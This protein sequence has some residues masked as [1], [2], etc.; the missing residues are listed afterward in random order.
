MSQ[1]ESALDADAATMCSECGAKEGLQPCAVCAAA[2]CGGQF[3]GT[4]LARDHARTFTCAT[5]QRVM[6]NTY[7][8]GMTSARG[9]AVQ[10]CWFCVVKDTAQEC[11]TQLQACKARARAE[12][13][14]SGDTLCALLDQL[15]E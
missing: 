14:P 6:C 13:T 4:C 8:E 2:G 7:E 5:C 1:T 9:D 11:C 15:F 10:L 3:C 12:G